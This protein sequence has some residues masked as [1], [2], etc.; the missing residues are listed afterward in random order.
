MI[1]LADAELA[2]QARLGS[3]RALAEIVRRH[4]GA[5]RGFL[6]SLG[7]SGGD[8][9][10][11]AQE[12]FLAAFAALDRFRGEASLRAWLCGIA[13][14]KALASRRSTLR[15]MA[16]DARSMAPD[17][18]VSA[19]PML[20]QRLDLEAAFALLNL[21]QRAAASLCF[22]LDMSHAEAAA[23]L[24]IPLG[25]LKSRVAAARRVLVAALKDEG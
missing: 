3:A 1:D 15:A 25:T 11:I 2:A 4:Q 9:D 5:V 8:A 21:D 6:R 19:A 17:P 18:P 7:G 10:D 22:G 16:R 13:W 23:A 20:D 12:T 24:E 14:R